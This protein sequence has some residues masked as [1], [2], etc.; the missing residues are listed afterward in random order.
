MIPGTGIFHKI[1]SGL[2]SPFSDAI[3]EQYVITVDD[4]YSFFMDILQNVK[5]GLPFSS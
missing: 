4:T 2:I 5:V 3:Y 1:L